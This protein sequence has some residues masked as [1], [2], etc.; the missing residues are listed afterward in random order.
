M[1]VDAVLPLA[2]DPRKVWVEEAIKKSEMQDIDQ[3]YVEVSNLTAFSVRHYSM[4]NVCFLCL[5]FP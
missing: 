1:V 4:I 3:F 2:I 5:S